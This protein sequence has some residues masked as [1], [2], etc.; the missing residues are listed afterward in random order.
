MQFKGIRPHLNRF[1]S[2]LYL[3]ATEWSG[4]GKPIKGICSFCQYCLNV[5]GRLGPTAKISTPWLLNSSYS[6]RKRANCARQYGHI[7]PRRKERTTGWPRKSDKR[8]KF[9][10]I[11][12]N[13][14]SGANSPGVINLFILNQFFG[15]CPN[16]IEHFYR[17]PA[18][19]CILLTGVIGTEDPGAILQLK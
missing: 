12:L 17:Q 18:C 8:I 19:E 6:S 14:K 16:L 13:S 1:T 4:S 5:E 9:P 15:F 11:S 2:C 3:R 10:S 7:K